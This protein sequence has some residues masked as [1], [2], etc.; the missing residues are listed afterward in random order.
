MIRMYSLNWCLW[1]VLRLI[2]FA[3]FSFLPLGSFTLNKV[4]AGNYD[5]RY[6]DLSNGGLSR[7]E[8]FALEETATYNGVQYSKITMTL[9]KVQNGNMRT[10]SLSETEF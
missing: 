10:Y 9:Y 4:I 2:R 8:V 7:S 1:T 5:I 3:S 6:R